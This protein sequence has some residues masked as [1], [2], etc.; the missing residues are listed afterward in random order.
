[1][2]R[3]LHRALAFLALGLF[4]ASCGPVIE[5]QYQLIPPK[6]QQGR[7]MV[8]QCQ[9]TQT[10]CRHA[11]SYGKQACMAE[12]RSNAAWEYQRYVAERNAKKEPLK[13]SPDSFVESWRCSDNDCESDCAEDFRTCFATAGGTVIPRQVCTAFCN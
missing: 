7:T 12:A 3:F 11:C 9:Q 1:M 6:N 13:R 10:M 2:P 5:T 8:M 4:L